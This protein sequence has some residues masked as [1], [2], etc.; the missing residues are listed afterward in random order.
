VVATFFLGVRCCTHALGCAAR[1][2]SS[3]A[4]APAA[5]TAGL[6]LAIIWVQRVVRPG[7][8]GLENGG[9]GVVIYTI[10]HSDVEPSGGTTGGARTLDWRAPGRAVPTRDLDG[11]EA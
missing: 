9:V 11:V 4:A 2:R 8:P 7:D 6:E 1:Q 5:L 10:G 3:F